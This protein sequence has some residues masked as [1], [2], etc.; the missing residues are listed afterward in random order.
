MRSRE[1]ILSRTNPQNFFIS[2][3]F[4]LP[5]LFS[6]DRRT[7]V[8]TCLDTFILMSAAVLVRGNKSNSLHRKISDFRPSVSSSF[9]SGNI[10]TGF[11]N[12][13]EMGLFREL[14]SII[15]DYS[16]GEVTVCTSSFFKTPHCR[17]NNLFFHNS[18]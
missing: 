10:S 18:H 4:C 5:Y 7:T 2:N 1:I 12:L 15:D 3:H 9:V 13:H 16:S 11:V 17:N 8:S 6:R 14:A